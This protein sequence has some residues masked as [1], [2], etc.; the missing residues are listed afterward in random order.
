MTRL[1][2]VWHD[3]NGSTYYASRREAIEAA[4]AQANRTGKE[5][6]VEVCTTV[7]GGRRAIA[8]KMLNGMG[9][10]AGSKVVCYIKPREVSEEDDGSGDAELAPL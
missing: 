10:C 4:Q 7:P 5:A 3:K 8:V 6:T 9:W 1:F 2:S